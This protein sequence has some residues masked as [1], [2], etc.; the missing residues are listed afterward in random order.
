MWLTNNACISEYLLNKYLFLYNPIAMCW[1]HYY[2]VDC[3]LSLSVFA[4]FAFFVCLYI[5]IAFSLS[6]TK[7]CFLFSPIAGFGTLEACS[8]GFNFSCRRRVVGPLEDFFWEP[9]GLAAS[10]GGAV[11]TSPNFTSSK[12]KSNKMEVNHQIRLQDSVD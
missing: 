1:Q 9:L 2:C 10:L 7:S 8:L 5:S 3:V 6:D 12:H 11:T 4:C